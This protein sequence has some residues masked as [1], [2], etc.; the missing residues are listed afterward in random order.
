MRESGRPS[1]AGAAAIEALVATKDL[2][3]DASSGLFPVQLKTPN[4]D[5]A[6]LAGERCSIQ[7]FQSKRHFRKGR[8]PVRVLIVRYKFHQANDV[9]FLNEPSLA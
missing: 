8:V 1:G 4:P 2:Q 6:I 3:I 7:I 9:E 5:G